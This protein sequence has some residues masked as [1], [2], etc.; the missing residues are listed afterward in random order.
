MLFF[1]FT[2][3]AL[4]STSPLNLTFSE[5]FPANGTLPKPPLT[6]N[7]TAGR[8][9]DQEPQGVF[10]VEDCFAAV[11]ALY[12]DHVITDPDKVYE[13]RPRSTPPKTK[14]PWM[15]LP[16]VYT[17]SKSPFLPRLGPLDQWV[18]VRKGPKLAHDRC[19]YMLPHDFDSEKLWAQG[20]ARW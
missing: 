14:N 13:F 15:Q 20:A 17:V 19:R 5:E 10:L 18:Y 6:T 2:L 1:A 8:R 9:C 4:T 7:L 11:Q 12:I 16:I 3:L